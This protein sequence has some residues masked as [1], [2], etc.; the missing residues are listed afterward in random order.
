[1][2]RGSLATATESTQIF[3]NISVVHVSWMRCV[4]DNKG[5]HMILS[6]YQ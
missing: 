2:Y 1:M 6:Q 5:L 4:N 3:Q